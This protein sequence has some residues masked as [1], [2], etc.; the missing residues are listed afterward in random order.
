MTEPLPAA[1]DSES[2]PANES[3][4][5]YVSPMFAF[6]L[7]TNFESSFT[8]TTP[9]GSGLPFPYVYGAKVAIV[10]CLT[11]I[12]LFRFNLWRELAR[13]PRPVDLVLSVAVGLFV[14]VLW[15]GLD[16]LYPDLPFLGVR[17]AFDPNTLPPFQK[18][19]FLAARMTGL[20][21]LVPVFEELFWR[22]FL[23]R[24]L[25]DSEYQ[26]VPVGKVT[27]F[28]AAATSVLFALA[29]PEWLPALLT[30]LL[31]AW[32]LKRT[33]S[34]A[35]CVISHMAANLALGLY[36]LSTHHWKYW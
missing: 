6:L 27:W 3:W 23:M 35:A 7:L 30:G 2:P 19:L 14:I 16:G 11:A 31:W 32:L 1:A 29:H 13:L 21:L 12:S 36:V 22:S 25:I 9:N 33:K 24:F 15:I 17:T 26:N 10:G 5:P 8:S 34:L 18:G 20:V 4:I 28:S